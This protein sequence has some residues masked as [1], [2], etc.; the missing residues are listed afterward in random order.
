MRVGDGAAGAGASAAWARVVTGAAVERLA[1]ATLTGC[2][3]SGGTARKRG[4][5]GSRGAADWTCT[6]TP[7]DGVAGVVAT[8]A[9]DGEAISAGTAR[10]RGSFGSR[11]AADQSVSAAHARRAAGPAARTN[12]AASKAGRRA[13]I[14]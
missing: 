14:F 2:N 9:T 5:F 12:S 1:L 10:K 6:E 8:L 11:G 4:S 3:I 13:A 7:T